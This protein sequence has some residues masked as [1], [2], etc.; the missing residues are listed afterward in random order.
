MFKALSIKGW[1][2]KI[3][4]TGNQF[5]NIAKHRVSCRGRGPKLMIAIS[6]V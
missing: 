3:E 1:H 6:I 4:G 2:Q 5:L